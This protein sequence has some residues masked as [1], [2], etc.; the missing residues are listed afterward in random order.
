M[1]D[2][3]GGKPLMVTIDPATWT[4]QTLHI[5]GHDLTRESLTE[6]L[7]AA[8]ECAGDLETT[9]AMV[10]ANMGADVDSDMAPVRRL[11]AAVARVR[12]E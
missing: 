4:N 12:G 3:T 11:R 8:E 9:I 2:E 7:A 6:L 1:T 5:W 10:D